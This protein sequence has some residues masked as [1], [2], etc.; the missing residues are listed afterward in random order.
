VHI[1]SLDEYL[2]LSR[3]Q[4][5]MAHIYVLGNGA[6][7]GAE[8][9]MQPL[10]F[11][12]KNPVDYR[13]ERSSQKYVVFTVPQEVNT[14]Q[15][16]YDGQGPVLQNLGFMPVFESAGAGDIVYTRFYNVYLPAYIV[17]GLALL[18]IVAFLLIRAKKPKENPS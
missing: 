13:I 2:K 17:S 6:D 14:E 3:E 16:K 12:E 18:G 15:W 9:G 1:Q 10:N 8:R 5:V 11:K 4:D 7:S